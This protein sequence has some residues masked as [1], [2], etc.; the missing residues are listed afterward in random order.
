MYDY[1]ATVLKVVDGDTIHFKIDQG[2][3]DETKM[4]VRLYG[5]N[6]PEMSTPEGQA[7]RQFV[8]EWLY[9]NMDPTTERVR[10]YTYKDRREKYGRYLADVYP[11][12]VGGGQSLSDA[13]VAAGH[14]ERRTYGRG[15][16]GREVPV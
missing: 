5:V 15:E 12:K 8:I 11:W 7:A 14:A 4:S 16:V 9:K 2:L 13:L 1:A 3:D 6:A 10:V